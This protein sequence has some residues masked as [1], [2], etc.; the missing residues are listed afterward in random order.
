MTDE[1][2]QQILTRLEDL[3]ERVLR[4]ERDS[5]THDGLLAAFAQV[6]AGLLAGREDNVSDPDVRDYVD[7]AELEDD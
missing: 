7:T 5:V 3:T 1:Q 2:V 6:G 4:L